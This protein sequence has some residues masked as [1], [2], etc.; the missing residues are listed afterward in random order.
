MAVNASNAEAH[1]DEF[2]EDSGSDDDDN[3]VDTGAK[4]TFK[5][6][7]HE[8]AQVLREFCHILEYQEQFNDHRMLA[9]LERDGAGLLRLARNCISSEKRSN[10]SRSTTPT[11]TARLATDT[12]FFR[13]RPRPSERQT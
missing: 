8:H 4:G 10:S 9:A 3:L 1:E 2:D 13:I 12:T 6:R 7:L 11:T 5:E